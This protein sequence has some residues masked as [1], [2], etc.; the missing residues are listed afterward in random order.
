MASTRAVECH[1]PLLRMAEQPG[2]SVF[3]EMRQ[4]L[5]RNWLVLVEEYIIRIIMLLLIGQPEILNFCFLIISKIMIFKYTLFIFAVSVAKFRKKI[6]K[7]M[8]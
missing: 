2:N 8:F 3:V 4:Y 5:E 7:L 1:A 6:L